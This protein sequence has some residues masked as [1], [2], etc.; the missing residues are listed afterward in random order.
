MEL[1][2]AGYKFYYHFKTELISVYS[3]NCKA[4]FGQRHTYIVSSDVFAQTVNKCNQTFVKTLDEI[5]H[6]ADVWAIWRLVCMDKSIDIVFL[7]SLSTHK[8]VMLTASHVIAS[9]EYGLFSSMLIYEWGIPSYWTLEQ[10]KL[11]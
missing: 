8:S 11:R 2:T 9:L 10:N 1:R 5:V 7:S 6:S 3:L 4:I